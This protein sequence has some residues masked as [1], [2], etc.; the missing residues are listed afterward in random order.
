MRILRFEVEHEA[1]HGVLSERPHECAEDQRDDDLS[2]P[3]RLID[4]RAREK[5]RDSRQPHNRHN[6]GMDVRE[7][8]QKIRL[9]QADRHI[10]VIGWHVR[11][12]L[13]PW[14]CVEF[15]ADSL[16]GR[17]EDGYLILPHLFY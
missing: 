4:D 17:I 6:G 11:H 1:V 7:E 8:L 2:C 12:R 3:Q 16:A 9:E 14:F 13:L 15:P 10:A 5:I